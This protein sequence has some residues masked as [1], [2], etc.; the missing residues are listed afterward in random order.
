LDAFGDVIEFA[1]PDPDDPRL[2]RVHKKGFLE[3]VRSLPESEV[4]GWA[5]LYPAWFDGKLRYCP[6]YEFGDGTVAVRVPKL[7]ALRP[8]YYAWV[9]GLDLPKLYYRLVTLTLYREVGLVRAWSKINRWVSA[10]LNR[11]RV[12]L[13][14]EFGVGIFY[15]WVV[16][17]HR[18]GFPHVHILFGLDR[19]VPS[20]TFP[21]LLRV[22]Q[23]AWVD[24]EGRPLCAPQGVDIRY[25]GCNV[26]RVKGYVLE[27]LVKDHWEVWGFEVK[28]GLV[29]ARLSTLLIWL[30]RVR[31][32]GMSQKLKR[33]ERVRKGGVLYH[34]R[35]SLRKVYVR[36]GYDMPYEEFKREFLWRGVLKFENRYLP[37][38][39]P[40][41]ANRGVDVGPEEGGFYRELVERF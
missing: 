38:L 39:V 31:L 29:R 11:V 28:D 9:R 14:R 36:V 18:D 17:V 30:F 21:V 12:K 4:L 2:A 10:C 8:D 5:K 22:F 1:Y 34:G 3:E 16:E 13:K 33:P 26:Q 35:V 6:V 40:S 23:E 32:F 24:E 15:L 19:F 41:V 20:L 27:Y 37:V 7:R 25:V